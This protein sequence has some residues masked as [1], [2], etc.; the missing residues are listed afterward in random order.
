MVITFTG[1]VHRFFI[2]QCHDIHKS[3]LKI[4]KTF[5]QVSKKNRKKSKKEESEKV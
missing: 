3:E 4:F 5:S 1:N 2:I